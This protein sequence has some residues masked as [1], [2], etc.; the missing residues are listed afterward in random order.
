MQWVVN[1]KNCGYQKELTKTPSRT[2]EFFIIFLLLPVNSTN[3]KLCTQLEVMGLYSNKTKINKLK[4]LHYIHPLDS[5][6]PIPR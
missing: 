6:T 4:K 5:D 3:N 1:D 2:S